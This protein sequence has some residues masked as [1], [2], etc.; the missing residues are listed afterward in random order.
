M[1]I[2]VAMAIMTVTVIVLIACY[3]SIV[4]SMKESDFFIKNY[5]KK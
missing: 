3:K 4:T 5:K 1:I 2:A